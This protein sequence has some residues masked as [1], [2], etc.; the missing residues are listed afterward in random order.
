MLR[1]QPILNNHYYHVFNRGIDKR[2]IF[3]SEYD[4]KRFVMLLH[5]CNSSKNV[6]L[7]N[8]VNIMNMEYKDILSLDMDHSLVDIGPWCLMSNHFHIV[9][10]QKVDNGI[11]TF[12]KRLGTG[13]SMYFNIKYQ[14]SGA[15]FGGPFKS[16]LIDNDDYMRYLFQY[17][18]WNPLDIQFPKWEPDY[19]SDTILTED[20]LKYIAEYE[21]SSIRDFNR[22]IRPENIIINS[23]LYTSW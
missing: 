10:H 5:V 7:D 13:F 20:Q 9:L 3:K 12:M 6:R 11:S 21:F 2:I 8:L 22:E 23:E 1:K 14:R 18:H 19:H 17:I 4:F 16:V 15:L